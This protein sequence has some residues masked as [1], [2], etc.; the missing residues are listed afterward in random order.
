MSD[1]RAVLLAEFRSRA[2]DGV[3]TGSLRD[4]IEPHGLAPS[5]GRRVLIDLTREGLISVEQTATRVAPWRLN[6]TPGPVPTLVPRSPKT[7]VS[8]SR[9]IAVDHSDAFAEAPSRP[10][11]N[12]VRLVAPKTF[13]PPT[14][15]FSMLGGRI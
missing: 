9:N 2:V 10:D 4:V 3:F 15:G 5:S 6:V 13:P 8:R 14:G 7:R 12:R 11:D 1:A